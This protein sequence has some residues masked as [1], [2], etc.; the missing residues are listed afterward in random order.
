MKKGYFVFVLI[1]LL[2][3]FVNAKSYS[4]EHA[5]INIL[6]NQDGSLEINETIEF[7]FVGDFSYAYRDFEFYVGTIEDIKVYDVTN[8]IVLLS[9]DITSTGAHKQQLKWY[10]S[11]SNERK[12][13]LISYKLKNS[14]NVYKDITEFYWKIWGNGWAYPLKE[15]SGTFEL[16]A[17]VSNP[18]DVYTYGHPQLNGK[19][20][21]LENKTVIF[22]AFNIPSNQWVELRVLFPSSLLSN[23]LFVNKINADGLEKIIQEENNYASKKSSNANYLNISLATLAIIIVIA[24]LILILLFLIFYFVGGREPKVSLEYNPYYERD[25][26]YNYSPAI[27]STLFNQASKKPSAKDF[28]ACILYLCIK[29]YCKLEVVKKKKFLVIF[30]KDTDYRIHLLKKDD[31]ALPKHEKKV[32]EIVKSYAEKND[33]ILFSELAGAA[34]TDSWHFRGQFKSW[35]KQV[36]EEA[37]AM[38]FFEKHHY[39]LIF[40]II[41]VAYIIL[42]FFVL[43][44]FPTI[45]ISGVIGLILNSTLL[46]NVLPRR[47]PNGAIHYHKWKTLKNY[48]KDFSQMKEHPPESIVLWEKYLV[49]ALTLG[50][51][52]KVEKSMKL[53]IPDRKAR[54]A[55][56]IGGVNY[57]SLGAGSFGFVSSVNS[58]SS[59]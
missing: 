25:I 41:C 15:I 55:I 45:T 20:A 50:V 56:F 3:S 43:V 31:H 40:N 5:E 27:V 11:A 37:L 8:S 7:N 35:Q 24:P 16:P 34:R 59:S 14:L 2:L 48:L 54:S 4:L 29:G 51:A 39:H 47:T 10:Y 13:F 6:V 22:Q 52:D 21:I 9:S 57:H 32:L 23:P 36:K 38:N 30:G 1:I 49:Y 42:G 26:P 46:K 18:K 17:A 33:S 53:M 58:F 44:I 28:V 19:I 12:R